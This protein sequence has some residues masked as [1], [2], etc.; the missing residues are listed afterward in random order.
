MTKFNLIIFILSI[1]LLLFVSS[2]ST[3]NLK[4][5]IILC[6]FL[7]A[8]KRKKKLLTY[9]QCVENIII[10]REYIHTYTYKKKKKRE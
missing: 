4:E 8:C 10:M 3:H 9:I 1:C 7:Y 2:L 6:V 5:I